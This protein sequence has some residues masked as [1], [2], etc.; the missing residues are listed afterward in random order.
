MN[1]GKSKGARR[2]A[3]LG[4]LALMALVAS[5]LAVAPGAAQAQ[6]DTGDDTGDDPL[7]T[8]P[9][10]S[11]ERDEANPH[12]AILVEWVWA[13]ADDPDDP[14]T[15]DDDHDYSFDV[16]IA[17]DVNGSPGDWSDIG[18]D[19][20]PSVSLSTEADPATG[21]QQV[22]L[23]GRF[24]HADLQPGDA[25]HHRVRPRDLQTEGLWATVGP[26][27]TE[28]LP[29]TPQPEDFTAVPAPDN[30]Q[31]RILFRWDSVSGTASSTV[32]YRIGMRDSGSEAWEWVD[33]I[34]S[35]AYEHR[36]S[37]P[38][39][40]DTY[41]LQ[42]VRDFGN[43]G[44]A[45]S[46]AVTAE[47]TPSQPPAPSGVSSSPDKDDL[48]GTV[49]ISWT[50][51]PDEAGSVLYYELR[52]RR[53]RQG[54]QGQRVETGWQQLVPGWTE[55][56]TFSHGGRSAGTTY[57]YQVRAARGGHSTTEYSDWSASTTV[58][59]QADIGGL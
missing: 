31:D 2:L 38:F 6:S 42:A 20:A 15:S 13:F 5:L 53:V 1:T 4:W 11:A 32:H 30:S 23:T 10:I 54:G 24:E 27:S 50:A 18:S 57:Q 34:Q 41:T 8:A 46:E 14:V 49:I 59:T 25:F 28:T 36:V 33:D 26:T 56:T 17:P 29:A 40:F 51:V 44:T 37:T 52:N 48:T 19:A 9:T 39:Q 45:V 7:S 16:Q 35:T 12:S 58:T 55:S 22:V 43:L 21:G 47:V 3:W